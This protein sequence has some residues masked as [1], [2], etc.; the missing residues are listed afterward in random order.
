MTPFYFDTFEDGT[1][2]ISKGQ[3][4]LFFKN[5]D[6][7]KDFIK[8]TGMFVEQCDKTTKGEPWPTY[9]TRVEQ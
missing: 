2:S 9:V 6:E 3:D 8:V 1:L 5:L 7:L 4:A